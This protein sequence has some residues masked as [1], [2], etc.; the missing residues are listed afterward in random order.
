MTEEYTVPA[1]IIELIYNQKLPVGSHLSAQFLADHLSLSR[2][3]INKAL[4]LLEEKGIVCRQPHK[5]CFLATKIEEPLDEFLTDLELIKKDPVNHVYFQI[6]EDRLQGL[7]DNEFSEKQIK[8]RYDLTSVQLQAVLGR[9]AEEGWAYKKPGYGWAF[10]PMLTTPESLIQTYRLRLALE[11]AALLEPGYHL[12]QQTLERCKET[13]IKILEEGIESYTTD[14]LHQR[15][16]R[17]H[18]AL[19]EASGNPFFIDTINRIHRVRRLLSYRS[20]KDRKRH[21]E[22][23]RQHLEILNLLEQNKNAEASEALKKHLESTIKNI[24]E[25]SNLL[26]LKDT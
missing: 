8:K 11:P 20:M 7:L 26:E 15:G 3:P 16:V 2:S 17:F 12:D 14:Q 23:A 13:E 10:S 21:T 6:A 4:S 18:V 22:H 24:S 19:V 9:I 1:Q 25:I 5:G